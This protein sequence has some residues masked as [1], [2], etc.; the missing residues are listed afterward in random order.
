[1]W[2]GDPEELESVL[3]CVVG[4][5]VTLSQCSYHA[6]VFR[7]FPWACL[8]RDKRNILAFTEPQQDSELT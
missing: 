5:C 3:L 6:L 1:M 2:G 7:D 4:D 8:E